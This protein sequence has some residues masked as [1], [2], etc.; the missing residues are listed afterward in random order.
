MTNLGKFNW[1]R[2]FKSKCRC[3]GRVLTFIL[4]RLGVIK[5][6]TITIVFKFIVK[7][8]KPEFFVINPHGKF[9]YHNEKRNSNN[10]SFLGGVLYK[11]K[12]VEIMS[13]RLLTIIVL[14]FTSWTCTAVSMAVEID[15]TPVEKNW[16]KENPVVRVH[17]EQ[18]WPPFNF[19]EN[20]KPSG[21]AIDY[22]NLIA[23]KT[24]LRI[25]FVTGPT[26]N[27]FL[28]MM[29]SG[30][31]DIMLNI[32]R[33]PERMKY[34]LYT[35][36]YIFKTNTILSHREND[37]SNL[38]ELFGKTVAVPK[39]FFQKEV[40]ER[41]FP[42]IKLYLVNDTLN[43]MEA[44]SSG[45]ADAAVGDV[46]VFDYFLERGLLG[47]L[48]ISGELNFGN[49][50]NEK[51]WIATRKDLPVLKS[52]LIKGMEAITQD[53]KANI[54]TSSPGIAPSKSKTICVAFGSNKAPFVF[55]IGSHA[56]LEVDIVTEALALSGI[57]IAPIELTNKGLNRILEADDSVMAAVGIQKAPNL[58]YYFSDNHISYNHLVYTREDE[59][60]RLSSIEDLKGRRIA[61]W[62]D[63]YRQLGEKFFHIFNPE[64]RADHTPEFY[65]ITDQRQQVKA[66]FDGTVDTLIIDKA[67]FD[68]Q[69]N[70][71]ADELDTSIPIREH[72]LF[73]ALSKSFVAFKSREL[74]D[75]FNIGLDT[76]KKNGRY[77]NLV[78]RYAD[79]NTPVFFEY[80]RTIGLLL[81]SFLFSGDREKIASL[82][83]KFSQAVPNSVRIKVWNRFGSEQSAGILPDDTKIPV[84]SVVYNVREFSG[85]TGG[86][87]Y[88]GKVKISFQGGEEKIVFPDLKSAIDEC[89][90][91]SQY[92]KN[93][94]YD[95]L[96]G[97]TKP[98]N[99]DLDTSVGS[100]ASGNFGIFW[101][102][103]FIVLIFILLLL[104][105]LVLPRVFTD[106]NLARHFNLTRF[107][108]IA[109]FMT[110]L[111]VMLIAGLVW[112]TLEK[113]KKAILKTIRVKLEIVLLDTQERLNLWV[114]E[115]QNFLIQLGHDPELVSITK[116]LLKVPADAE[117]LTISHPLFEAR[118]FFVENGDAFG[119]ID[120]FIIN[121]N[122]ISIGS[123]WKAHLGVRNFIDSQ[124]TDLLDRA[125]KGEAVFIPPIQPKNAIND[126]KNTPLDGARQPLSMFF[127]VPIRDMDGSV[128]A[129]LTQRLLPE[130]R[131][132]KIV[133]FGHTDKTGESYLINQ[134]GVLLTKNHSK[135]QLSDIG[136]LEKGG[137]EQQQIIV[138]DPGGNMLEGFEP[139]IPYGER[140]LT[141]MAADLIRMSQ[142]VD[143]KG[144]KTENSNLVIDVNDGYR[145][146]RGVPVFG[147][148]LWDFHLGLGIASEIDV[149]DALAGFYA[150]RMSLLL[151]SGTTLFVTILAILITLMLG[152]RAVRAISLTR[153][154][155]EKSVKKRTAE[156]SDSL[157]EINFQKFALDQHA[158]VSSTDIYGK[159]TYAND[160]FCK[161]SGYSREELIGKNHRIIKS[162]EHPPEFFKEMWQTISK[163]L[164]WHGELKNRS[165]D[166]SYHWF[167]S[168]IVPFLNKD[169]NLHQ[170][171]SIRTD[172]TER[173]MIE[174]ELDRQASFIRV[175]RDTAMIANTAM[176]KN[177]AVQ[178]IL[179]LV[180]KFLGWPV[181][182]VYMLSDENPDLLVPSDIW[183]DTDRDKFAAFHKITQETSLKK[184][185]GLPGR[186]L[187]IG[188]IKWLPDVFLSRNFNR[189]NQA[190]EVGIKTGLAI[191]IMVNSEVKSVL[192]LYSLEHVEGDEAMLET[193]RQ[194]SGI[195][196][197]IEERELANQH[198][199]QA[200]E[201]AEA[202]TQAKSDF[203]ANMSHEIRTPMN[204][205]IGM[206]HLALQTDLTTK[207]KDYITK[208]FNAANSLLGLINDILDF[209]KIE[210]GKL[211]MDLVPFHLTDLLE[212]LISLITVKTKEKG[213]EL[214]I[215]IDPEVP[216]GLVGDSLRLRQVLIN[217]SNNAV[218]FTS[219]GEIILRVDHVETTDDRVKLQFSITD[220]GIGMTEEQIDKLFQSFSQADAS[221]TRKFGGT[222]LGLAISKQ[223]TEMMGGNIW[224]KSQPGKGSSFIFTATFG[225]SKEIKPVFRLPEHD[226]RMLRV[227]VV[228]DNV[229]AREIMQQ[230]TKNLFF[231]VEIVSSGEEALELV[232]SA[233]QAKKPFQL[234]FMD[235]KMPGMDG[236]ETFRAIKEDDDLNTSPRMVL[237]TAYDRDEVL[238]QM[239]EQDFE[240][241]VLSKPVTVSSLLDAT[242]LAL[243]YEEQ[244]YER[245]TKKNLEFDVVADIRGAQILLVEDNEAN[246]QVASE[247]LNMAQFVV[248]IANNGQEAVDWVNKKE[249]DCVLMDVQMPVM[250]GYEATRVIRQNDRFKDLPIL[251]M[252]ANAMVRDQDDARQAGM[253]DHLT[254]PI[255]PKGMFASLAKWIKPGYR[256]VAGDFSQLREGSEK[257][258][259]LLNIPGFD[260]GR[261]L[262]RM[263][264]SPKAYLKILGKVCEAEAD[265][266]DR[267]SQSLK[268]GNR[269][270]A[271]RAAHTLK[272]VAGTIGAVALESMAGQ[273]E[274]E[275]NETS[276]EPPEDLMVRVGA[277]LEQAMIKI[278]TVLHGGSNS[279]R[280]ATATK[281]FSMVDV[282]PALKDLAV[283]IDN[284]DSTAVEMVED[285]LTRVDDGSLKLSLDQLRHHLGEYDFDGAASVLDGILEHLHKMEKED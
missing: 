243:G 170:Y 77:D 23:S 277:G 267:I 173:K 56:G 141:R 82:L 146:Y 70:Q 95:I 136:L 102:L 118:E 9:S 234:I 208:V 46:A 145:D 255:D 231:E 268:E 51:L 163:G 57:E 97:Q 90:V 41:D 123:K 54:F 105:T 278:E 172:I 104:V 179:G 127:A 241:G 185:V 45:K 230:L 183:Y 154:Q 40:L 149:D 283:Q 3:S 35:T 21:F 8:Q 108:F 281:I 116:R 47:D 222:G 239:G 194:I 53:E 15:L 128:L 201:E 157:Q 263:G 130:G 67:I 76:L 10:Y 259:A 79:R 151:I 244:R 36:P 122:G 39:G 34:L 107:R 65:E 101:R 265:V 206:S 119:K 232:R 197:R 18:N 120:F 274:A 271:V 52:I 252:T 251:A 266:M 200:R 217:L 96:A 276:G 209:S 80:S 221:T 181:G 220:S 168:T 58:P 109:L 150:L 98:K 218:K 213:L 205:I 113:N 69:R 121:R 7:F 5:C 13:I 37:Y 142:D 176:S 11:K 111:M 169:S 219:R 202:S 247:L 60:V 31:L 159:I 226:V 83:K 110:S 81:K 16:L 192:E 188:D 152:E 33:T 68:W 125:F 22:M 228:D 249:F 258:G 285:L 156:L 245:Q 235:W 26:W 115:H 75:L 28:G 27:E 207:Q 38:E 49:P 191:P 55:E 210:A 44:V 84:Y 246:Q 89:Q 187:E 211:D 114:S 74:R 279:Q 196:C 256:E 139:R 184:G 103:I 78:K 42:Q 171:I 117:S 132:S 25:D 48:V 126:Q 229:T 178:E 62:E 160:K 189:S 32:V 280:T 166:G 190:R 6:P 162:D 92:E 129:V 261:A 165:R 167:N 260:V 198:L 203:L 140:P 43:S 161:I 236:I 270:E 177:R 17:N 182:H 100:Q 14:F 148:W 20:G 93:I 137:S 138:C 257:A 124:K 204:A 66:F 174:A 224:A 238:L 88:L 216:N 284:F 131:L 237:V 214:L 212:D 180:C 215:A 262:N 12:R 273:L 269:Q 227:L 155:L 85:D 61:I 195:L 63:G 94:L 193:I 264:G 59:G 91:C 233:D 199:M 135:E 147:A 1:H 254:K 225:L 153:D 143:L 133:Q 50:A 253:N 24:G 29:K 158:I 30:D 64:S 106:K 242:M 223:L 73:K 144:K 86:I 19:V 248:T 87:I 250:D 71:L 275:L 164:V 112:Y 240:M 282:I 186:A 175:L 4:D 99:S 272:G 134:E 72:H 2:G